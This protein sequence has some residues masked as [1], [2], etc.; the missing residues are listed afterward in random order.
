M[1]T[2]PV[3]LVRF[4]FAMT[5]CARYAIDMASMSSACGC[6]APV[7]ST[8]VV[9][10]VMGC[11]PSVSDDDDDDDDDARVTASLLLTRVRRGTLQVQ[12]PRTGPEMAQLTPAIPP[13]GPLASARLQ[14]RCLQLSTA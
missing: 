7:R 4:C 8:S 12:V 3:W 11:A 10:D 13:P 1:L 2:S 14:L 5:W 9:V 6:R